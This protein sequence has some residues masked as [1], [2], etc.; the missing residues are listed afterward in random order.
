MGSD[1]RYFPRWKVNKHVEYREAGRNVFLSYTK[2][3]SLDGASIVVFGNPPARRRIQL[4]I[5]LADKKNFEAEG[6]IAWSKSELTHKLLGIVFEN[7][8]KK[9]QG[10]ILHH[11][12]E[13]RENHLLIRG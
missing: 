2:D 8:S 11:A 10:L 4:K 6:R 5:H 12:F 13:L 7:L 9:A 1:N 3:L